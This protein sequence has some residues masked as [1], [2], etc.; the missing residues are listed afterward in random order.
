[1]AQQRHLKSAPITEAVV[2][3]RVEIRDGTAIDSLNVE[4]ISQEIGYRRIGPLV[5]GEF[6]FTVDFEGGASPQVSQESVQTIGARFHSADEKYVAQ[7]SLQGFT[8]SRLA[9]YADWLELEREAK[10]VWE[11]YARLLKPRAVTRVATRFINDLQLPNGPAFDFDTYLASFPGLPDPAFG[12]IS[13]FLLQH[14]GND[15]ETGASVRCTQALRP[16]KYDSVLPVVID[17]DVYRGH[18]FSFDEGAY[19]PYLN[20]LR[21]VKNRVF[22]ALLTEVCV[23]LYK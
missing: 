20:R 5:T 14:E 10:R 18:R 19:W 11:I 15:P 17:I 23:D 8:F 6:G 21:D 9:P 2:D 13:S 3:L 16:G 22:F 4:A 1:M 7:L 12:S